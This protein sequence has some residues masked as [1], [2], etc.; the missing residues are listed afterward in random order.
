MW[1]PWA[2]LLLFQCQ[3]S[4]K[5]FKN[6]RRL[7]S[8]H[9]LSM[10]AGRSPSYP[11]TQPV[12][13]TL[14]SPWQTHFF[15]GC[16]VQKYTHSYL[17]RMILRSCCCSVIPGGCGLALCGLAWGQREKIL[18]MT[19]LSRTLLN[20]M[21]NF[22]MLLSTSPHSPLQSWHHQCQGSSPGLQQQYCCLKWCLEMNQEWAD[23]LCF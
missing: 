19:G 23:Y 1:R 17:R 3:F 5:P 9:A 7:C 12:Y 2:W 8:A 11:P 14:T 15:T 16:L 20:M 18:T 6:P 13:S 10:T 4:Q 22:T 21:I